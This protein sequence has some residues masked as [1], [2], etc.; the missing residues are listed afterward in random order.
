MVVGE[1]MFSVS[2]FEEKEAER[3]TNKQKEERNNTE[4]VIFEKMVKNRS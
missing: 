2:I 1:E 4:L 3:Q